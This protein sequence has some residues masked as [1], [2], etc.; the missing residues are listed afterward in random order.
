MSNYQE[1]E[2]GENPAS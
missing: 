2:A 1:E